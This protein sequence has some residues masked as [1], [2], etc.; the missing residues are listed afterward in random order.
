MDVRCL[1]RNKFNKSVGD[2]VCAVLFD[3][4]DEAAFFSKILPST[5]LLI[6]SFSSGDSRLIIT[7]C[8]PATGPCRL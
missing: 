4:R 6:Y 1:P 8:A 3:R 7:H 2:L 5:R